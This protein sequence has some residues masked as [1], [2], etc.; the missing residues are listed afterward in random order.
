ML[1]RWIGCDLI[2]SF[3]QTTFCRCPERRIVV[4][5]MHE[6]RQECLPEYGS[7]VGIATLA[8][9]VFRIKLTITLWLNRV[10]PVRPS[11]WCPPIAMHQFGVADD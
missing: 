9:M 7:P 6:P 2:A 1:G 3:L 8:S 10:T 5:N 11:V 4:N